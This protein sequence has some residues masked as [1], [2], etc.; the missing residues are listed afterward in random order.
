[1]PPRNAGRNRGPGWLCCCFP[2]GALAFRRNWL[3]GAAVLMAATLPPQPAMASTW[4]DLWQ[5]PD[6]QAA[7]ALGA[8]DYPKAAA[9]A[10]DPALRGSAEYKRGNFQL[11]LDNFAHGT[12]A[13]ADYNRGNALARL[14]R[15]QDAVAAYDQSLK[16]N[17]GDPDAIANRAAVAALLQ[18]QQQQQQQQRRFKSASG[19]DGSPQGAPDQNK[20]SDQNS[21]SQK[22]G[23]GTHKDG[24]SGKQIDDASGNQ[25]TANKDQDGQAGKSG[26]QGAKGDDH[27]GKDS[28]QAANGTAKPPGA[29]AL[30]DPSQGNASA[31]ATQQPH[32]GESFAEA[33]SRLAAQQNNAKPD[34]AGPDMAA[35]TSNAG[36]PVAPLT[37]GAPARESAAVADRAKPLDSEEQ[38][39]AEQ[40]LRRIPDDP[41][42]LLR[43]KFLYQYRQRAQHGD[44]DDN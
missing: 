22:S 25:A 5:R 3:L 2:W 39:A 29:S 27:A 33:A 28:G 40:W 4:S 41:G 14:G 34:G 30:P 37:G 32:P 23:D 24:T 44:A 16:E 21:P 20:G 7:A 35:T 31:G 36:N 8:G 1:M 15:Y 38:M 13:A 10:P 6:Q 18:Q 11:A 26:G 19:K 17:P 42:G 12:G 43:R 9:L